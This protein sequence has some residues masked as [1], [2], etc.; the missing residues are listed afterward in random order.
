[1]NTGRSANDGRAL[2]AASTSGQASSL[3]ESGMSCM[4][5]IVAMRFFHESYGAT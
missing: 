5:R 4:K 1:M 3:G 2:P